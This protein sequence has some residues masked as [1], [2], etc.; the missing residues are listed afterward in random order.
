MSRRL[1]AVALV[2]SL[3]L[4]AFAGLVGRVHVHSNGVVH[5]HSHS[6][7]HDHADKSVPSSDIPSS[8]M[9]AFL[10]V[11]L[12]AA[13]SILAILFAAFFVI[14]RMER[15]VPAAVQIRA[16]SFE[17]IRDGTVR[18]PSGVSLT[19]GQRAPPFTSPI[20]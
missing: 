13:T 5:S 20:V 15:V 2:A 1:T 11:S 17:R 4:L 8:L 10:A 12:P 19:V 6:T 9:K 18:V 3:S 14:A 16:A 7:S